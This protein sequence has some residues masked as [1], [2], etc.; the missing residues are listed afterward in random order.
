[1]PGYVLLNFEDPI[2]QYGGA[3]Q[4]SIAGIG[5]KGNVKGHA[6]Q[7]FDCVE[8]IRRYI[9]GL[10]APITAQDLTALDLAC[11]S[12]DKI[13]V[14]IHGDPRRGAVGLTTDMQQLCTAAQ[15][16]VFLLRIVPVR[17][18]QY[19]ISMIM[20]YG[21]RS[22]T[23]Q[24]ALADH[25]GRMSPQILATSF[26]Y[27]LFKEICT[28]RNVRLTARTGRVNHNPGTG[29][30]NVEED[31]AID[32]YID[33]DE[34]NKDI[35]ANKPMHEG[36]VNAAKLQFYRVAGTTSSGRRWSTNIV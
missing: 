19:T 30:V 14:V 3:L 11:F 25:Q 13:Y 36:P 23:W 8:L 26:A 7:T 17:Q 21:A 1:M 9:T 33:M 20:C 22:A 29:V 32:E 4:S 27:R 35:I 12:A 31:M 15:L 28:L 2:G 6:V 24:H 5:V 16:A 18:A 34:Y 10:P